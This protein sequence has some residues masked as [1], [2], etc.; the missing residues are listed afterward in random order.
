MDVVE[1]IRTRRSIRKFSSKPVEWDKVGTVI[2]CG[3]LAPSAGNLQNWKF[4]V[5]LDREKR[6]K[7]AEACLQQHWI[8]TAPVII[9][10]TAE[11][12]KSERFYGVRGDR[13]YSIQNCAAAVENMLLAA[14]SAGLSS[15]WVGAFDEEMLKRAVG[16]SS[17]EVRPQAVVPIGYA[18]ET[19]PE[20]PKQPLVTVTFLE[21]YGSRISD[22]NEFLGY[23]S[24]K[25][26][27]LISKGREAL[28]KVAKKAA[29]K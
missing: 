5:V 21:S 13:L 1:C 23:T 28:Q 16:I 29:K 2:D 15:C 17:D 7:I 24:S 20:P 19:V 4:T 3:R 25:I 12:K 6:A 14:H 22:P 11:P 18:G 10:V 26:Q 27:G 8:H 9:V